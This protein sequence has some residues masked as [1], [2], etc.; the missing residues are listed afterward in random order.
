MLKYL[1][2][3]RLFSLMVPSQSPDSVPP[4]AAGLAPMPVARTTNS[5]ALDVLMRLHFAPDSEHAVMMLANSA[6]ASSSTAGS[7]SPASAHLSVRDLAPGLVGGLILPGNGLN[8]G[9]MTSMQQLLAFCFGYG[10]LDTDPALAE[11]SQAS[12]TCIEL[13]AAAPAPAGIRPAAYPTSHV[14]T[15]SSDWRAVKPAATA[16]PEPGEFAV[17]LQA[18]NP[19]Q[20]EQARTCGLFSTAGRTFQGTDGRM[21]QLWGLKPELDRKQATGRRLPWQVCISA[22]IPV[23]ERTVQAA[24]S[25][26]LAVFLPLTHCP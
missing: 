24:I 21:Y 13:F 23:D 15:L 12:A 10:P 3:Q 7:T 1:G 4:P 8:S 2:F 14:M 9:D 18:F 6:A 16:S 20:M 19:L 26:R 25:N 17:D 5:H 11:A 22:S